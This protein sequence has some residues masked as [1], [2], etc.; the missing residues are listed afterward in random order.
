M[1]S[2]KNVGP[3]CP[4]VCQSPASGTDE[5]IQ[6]GTDQAAKGRLY[7]ASPMSSNSIW[8]A[9][10]NP[11][12][13]RLWL[14]SVISGCCVSAHDMAATWV[15]NTL[16]P[17]PLLISLLSTAASLPFFLLTVP[18][19]AL[20]DIVDRRNLLCVMHLWLALA[21]GGLAVG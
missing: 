1:V 21:A 12:F 17:S 11:V 8:V 13:R 6:H 3:E 4:S 5:V 14:A 20:A 18:A 10:R 2:Y 9:L 16:T 7:P 15:M 19:G